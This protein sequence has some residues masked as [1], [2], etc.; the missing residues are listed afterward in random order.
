MIGVMG[1]IVSL[2]LWLWFLGILTF[3]L[4]VHFIDIPSSYKAGRLKYYSACFLVFKHSDKHW[5]IHGPTLFDYYFF[6]NQLGAK[7]KFDILSDFFRGFMA[8]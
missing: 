7:P 8:F 5:S 2:N 4:L 1:C 6:K 3:I